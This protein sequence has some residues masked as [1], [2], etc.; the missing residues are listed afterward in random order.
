MSHQLLTTRTIPCFLRPQFPVAQPRVAISVTVSILTKFTFKQTLK[1]IV[2]P[3]NVTRFI[4]WIIILLI[5]PCILHFN[6]FTVASYF[7]K[8]SPAVRTLVGKLRRLCDTLET[9]NVIARKLSF[10]LFAFLVQVRQTDRAV[11]SLS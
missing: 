11:L 10:L 2:S 1:V 7:V 3:T 8:S 5:C 9:K 4:L 6:P